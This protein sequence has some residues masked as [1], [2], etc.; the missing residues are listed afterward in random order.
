MNGIKGCRVVTVN[1]GTTDLATDVAFW[2]AVFQAQG[3][4]S[5][6]PGGRRFHLGD[7][8]GFSML[9]LRVRGAGEPHYGHVTGFGL[10][11]DDLDA[12]HARALAAG[13]T[14]RYAPKICPGMPRHSSIVDPGGNR[15]VLWQA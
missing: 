1:L 2:E 9:N 11:V 4:P 5:S 7:G 15:V 13:A 14:E 8:D 3:E 12:Y 10:A 6:D